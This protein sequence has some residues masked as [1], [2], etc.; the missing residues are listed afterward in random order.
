MNDNLELWNK[1]LKPH[2]DATKKFN[3]AGGFRGTAIDPMWLIRCAT[4]A[5]GPMGVNWGVVVQKEEYREFPTDPVTVIHVVWIDLWHGIGDDKGK[6]TCVGQTTMMGTNKNGV[7]VDEEAPKKSLTDAIGK[8][9]SWLGF[10]AAVH[11]GMFDGNK[12][13]D[14]RTPNIESEDQKT[15]PTPKDDLDPSEDAKMDSSADTQVQS[16]ELKALLK[17]LSDKIGKDEALKWHKATI[18]NFFKADT[19]DELT[20]GDVEKHIYNIKT[21]LKEKK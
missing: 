19:I 13:V 3:K 20:G 6:I 8:G 2:K 10:G 7:F 11:M 9:L 18:K 12:Y 17:E 14:L 1:Y 4:E 21:K 16:S 5:W 15:L